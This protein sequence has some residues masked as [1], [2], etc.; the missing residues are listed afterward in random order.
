ML[1]AAPLALKDWQALRCEAAPPG[2]RDEAF[3]VGPSPVLPTAT[4]TAAVWACVSGPRGRG[5]PEAVCFVRK[6]RCFERRLSRGEEASAPW[7]LVDTG[8]AEGRRPFSRP[9]GA[10][11]LLRLGV[12][13]V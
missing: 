11:A 5:T 9:V 7:S 10:R 8:E 13:S 1:A 2:K 12:S 4:T 6:A 3:F